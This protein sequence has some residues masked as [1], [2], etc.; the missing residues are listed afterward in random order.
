LPRRERRWVV[1][2]CGAEERL[3]FEEEEE[4]R[5]GDGT[6]GLDRQVW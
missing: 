6:G 4:R 2:A 5:A 3:G 1:V